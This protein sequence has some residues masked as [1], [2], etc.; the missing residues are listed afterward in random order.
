M[1]HVNPVFAVSGISAHLSIIL[2]YRSNWLSS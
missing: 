2:L 1:S